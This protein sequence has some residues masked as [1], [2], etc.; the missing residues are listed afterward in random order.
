L[1]ALACLAALGALALIV[2]VG[3]ATHDL[4]RVIVFDGG[5]SSTRVHV[6][7]LE[8]PRI[9]KDGKETLPVLRRRAGVRKVHPGLASFKDDPDGI[10]AY[11]RPLLEFAETSIP[12]DDRENTPALL[13]ATAGVRALLEA[14]DAES[15]R[16]AAAILEACGRALR[17]SA[18][19]RDTRESVRVLSGAEEGLYAWI[20]ANVAAGT[21]YSEPAETVGVIE[22]GGASVQIAFRPEMKPP[23]E[24]VTEFKSVFGNRKWAV[25]AHSALGLGLDV[26]R[27]TYLEK[28]RVDANREGSNAPVDPCALAEKGGLPRGNFTACRLACG[29]LL[30]AEGKCGFGSE[31][32]RDGS[33]SGSCGVGGSYLPPLRGSFLATENFAHTV[34][35]LF[36][37]R[38]LRTRPEDATVAAVARAGEA[39]CASRW[40]GE[41]RRLVRG[42]ADADDAAAAAAAATSVSRDQTRAASEEK[43]PFLVKSDFDA[44]CFASSYVVAILRDVMSVDE[45]EPNAVRFSD[46]LDGIAVDW[47]LGAGI[48]HVNTFTRRRKNSRILSMPFFPASASRKVSI[49]HRTRSGGRLWANLSSDVAA[50]VF[51]ATAIAFA[52]V[53]GGAGFLF[54]S[55]LVRRRG[56]NRTGKETGSG[57]TRARL[58]LGELKVRRTLGM[59]SKGGVASPTRKS[60]ADGENDGKGN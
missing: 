35:F 39:L 19:S 53:A 40:D 22:L 60:G 10:D 49:R 58:R 8:V 27:A 59:P 47:A 5:S 31:T 2:T 56:G 25:Y 54:V 4:R 48:A 3:V 16:S 38:F 30:D 36:D 26:A 15:E 46:T 6:F 7:E 12:R 55:F 11:L 44:S 32:R 42:D 18:F 37:A 33:R 1:C 20:A 28:V 13:F 21:I 34:R 51:A 23:K 14:D 45:T 50:S 41:A 43:K 17:R 57:R 29:A 24:Y 9:G 52:G